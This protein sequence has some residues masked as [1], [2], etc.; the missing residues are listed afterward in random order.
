[1]D[2]GRGSIDRCPASI[3]ERS[4]VVDDVDEVFAALLDRVHPLL[5]FVRQVG[6]LQ[7]FG[8]TEH[9]SHRGTDLVARVRE[10]RGFQ[11]TGALDFLLGFL[12]DLCDATPLRDVERDDRRSREVRVLGERVTVHLPDAVAPFGRRLVL[13]P[14]QGSIDRRR[15]ARELLL[16]Q[17]PIQG[18][19]EVV[20][21]CEVG[22]Q[23][24]SVGIRGQD[25]EGC[26]LH[27]GFEHS[28]AVSGLP[29][30]GL[31]LLDLPIQFVPFG[32]QL[33]AEP[34]DPFS[35][36]PQPSD[37]QG[38]AGGGDHCNA[39]LHEIIPQASTGNHEEEQHLM[40]RE[41]ATAVATPSRAPKM[42]AVRTIG[43]KDSAAVASPPTG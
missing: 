40:D 36:R 25:G 29:F 42:D 28:L 1:M 5:L 31:P 17:V 16:P 13:A 2:L 27:G 26:T 21:V 22:L 20:V 34:V 43:R 15:H 12:A 9:C 23:E 7:E 18:S 10:E 24:L 35:C 39:A 38:G 3:L 14:L 4:D 33:R 37:P 30:G 11:P 41:E 6:S 19:G 32:H 8:A